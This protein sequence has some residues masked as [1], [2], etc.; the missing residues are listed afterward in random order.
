LGAGALFFLGITF[1]GLAT[2]FLAGYFASATG[3]FPKVFFID[4]FLDSTTLVGGTGLALA[5]AT[6]GFEGSLTSFL[7]F[8]SSSLREAF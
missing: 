6:T 4:G 5:G 8:F 2:G 7:T 3:F 1:Y